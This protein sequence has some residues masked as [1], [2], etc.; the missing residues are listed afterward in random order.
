M[1]ILKEDNITKQ[2]FDGPQERVERGT[3]HQSKQY[4]GQEKIST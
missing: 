1:N 4:E 3:A 2:L